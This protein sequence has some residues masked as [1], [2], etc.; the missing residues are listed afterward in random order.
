MKA[1]IQTKLKAAAQAS[2]KEEKKGILS[3]MNPAYLAGDN[4]KYM[5]M[6]NKLA[7][8][9]DFGEKW[10]GR[11]KYGRSIEEMRAYLMSQLEWKDQVS[12]LYVSIGTGADLHFLPQTVDIASLD[13]V[14]LDISL[15]MLEKCHKT[16]AKKTNLTLVHACAEDLPFA[17]NTFDIVLHVGGINF[18]SDR[19]KAL[20]EMIRV[21]KPGTKLLVADE[22]ADY[23]DSQYKKN[24]LSKQYFEDASFNLKELEELLPAE[25]IDK[26]LEF[27]WENRFYALTF[28]KPL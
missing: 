2:I 11:I 20:E 7:P 8:W 24:V 25:V 1:E 23:V 18:F 27:I 16:W 17:D 28:R 26:K 5:T 21:A 4:Q 3:Y 22:T 15:G 14:G 9:Y 6:Y 10:I 12:V 13:L 19:Q